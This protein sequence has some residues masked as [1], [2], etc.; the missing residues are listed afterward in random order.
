[1]EKPI[2]LMMEDM[3]GNPPKTVM[4]DQSVDRVYDEVVYD[5]TKH[6]DYLDAVLKLEAVAS[7]DWLTNK[8][9]RCVTGRVAKQQTVGALQLPLNDCGVM[10]LD[11]KGKEGVATSVGH[12]PVSA[13]VDPVA[14]SRNSVAEALTNIV[15]A[16]LAEGLKS[17]SLSANWMWACNNEGEDA[18]LY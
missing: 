10:A 18:R 11:Y 7:K 5:E 6:K 16:P 4:K 14:G 9:D 2:D 3:F 13:L 17:V 15:W 8:V 12:S 1:G